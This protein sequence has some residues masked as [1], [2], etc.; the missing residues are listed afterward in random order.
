[1]AMPTYEVWFKKD[2]DGRAPDAAFLDLDYQWAGELETGSVK[3]LA[4][5]VAMTKQEDSKLDHHRVLRTG[6]VVRVK[7]AVT[8]WMMTPV[9]IWAQVPTFENQPDA[10]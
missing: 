6:D 9:G 3:E 8:G 7:G 4:R 10:H 1:M 2:N 5:Y